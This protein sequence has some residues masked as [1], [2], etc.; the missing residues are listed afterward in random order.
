MDILP[1]HHLYLSAET[2]DTIRN[3][4]DVAAHIAAKALTGASGGQRHGPSSPGPAMGPEEALAPEGVLAA[5][6]EGEKVQTAV[7]ACHSG[8]K[9]RQLLRVRI[10]ISAEVGPVVEVASVEG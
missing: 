1:G 7:A 4:L 9:H 3:R 5:N 2:Y 8:H 6:N 10:C